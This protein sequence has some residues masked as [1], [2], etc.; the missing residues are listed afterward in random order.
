MTDPPRS[1]FARVKTRDQIDDA[2]APSD[3]GVVTGGDSTI[4]THHVC[5]KLHVANSREGTYLR[6]SW[7]SYAKNDDGADDDDGDGDDDDGPRHEA[8]K[9]VFLLDQACLPFVH[10][11]ELDHR[12][13]EKR[14]HYRC[15]IAP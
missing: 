11:F 8:P 1:N 10:Y 13:R 7:F 6:V 14:Q 5:S 9:I 2:L 12:K 15:C 4:A 3:N